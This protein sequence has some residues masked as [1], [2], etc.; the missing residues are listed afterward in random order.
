M[1]HPRA[2]RISFGATAA[3]LILISGCGA[4]TIEP[5]LDSADG[6]GP[7]PAEGTAAPQAIDPEKV[8]YAWYGYLADYTPVDKVT[9]LT[10]KVELVVT[11]TIEPGHRWRVA[12]QS[13]G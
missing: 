5:P 13:R 4:Q 3:V 1:A 9:E 7:S 8:E 12:Q 2:L 10:A 11:G 6:G